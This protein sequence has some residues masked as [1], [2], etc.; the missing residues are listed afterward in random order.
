MFYKIIKDKKVIG[1]CTSDDLRM[2]QQKH[3]LLLACNED[4]AQYI[5]CDDILYRDDWFKDTTCNIEWIY[6]EVIVIE[7][8]EYNTLCEMFKTNETLPLIEEEQLREDF[9]DEKPV[10]DDNTLEGVIEAK[11]YQMSIACRKAIIRGFD[12]E[13]SDGNI[14]HFSYKK[15]SSF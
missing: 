5:S 15:S 6:A 9:E 13:L 8:E 7:E 2:Y 3:N 1:V 12:L 10:V 11:I 14:H 4:R